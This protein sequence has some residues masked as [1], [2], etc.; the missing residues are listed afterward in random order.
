MLRVINQDEINNTPTIPFEVVGLKDWSTRNVLF[1]YTQAIPMATWKVA[2]NLENNPDIYVYVQRNGPTGAVLA[3]VY[4]KS[5]D[6]VDLNN[7]LITFDQPE[8]GVAQC[9]ALSSQNA[10]TPSTRAISTASTNNMQI[11]HNGELTFATLDPSPLISIKVMFNSSASPQPVVIE[12]SNIATTSIL[13]P[14]DGANYV[15]I[16]S[17]RY[18]TKSVNL[19]TWGSAPI[20]FQAGLIAAGSTVYFPNSTIAGQLLV[21]LANNPQSSIADRIY[22][23]YVDTASANTPTPQLYYNTGNVY[24]APSMIRNTYPPIFAG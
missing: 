24:V 23:R 15:I 16:N 8:A 14:W 4:P 1:N 11:S 19:L 3:E 13:S 6:I 9:V 2:H 7:V 12:Y 10:V 5:I 17:K 18:Y 22:D 20:V 21:L